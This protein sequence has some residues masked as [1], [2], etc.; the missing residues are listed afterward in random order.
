MVR[1]GVMMAAP[2]IPRERDL[3]RLRPHLHEAYLDAERRRRPVPELTARQRQLLELL[4]AGYTNPQAARRL[5][6]S[7]GTVR[8]HLENVYR[9]LGVTNRTAALARAE[10][11]LSG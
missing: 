9:R 3:S 5:G 8:K 1:A 7:E 11:Q 10:S 4:A 6:L 2:L